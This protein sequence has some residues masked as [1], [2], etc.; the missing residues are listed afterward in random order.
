MRD[1]M[2]GRWVPVGTW[3][4]EISAVAAARSRSS[5][6]PFQ[7]TSFRIAATSALVLS[8][9]TSTR[10]SSACLIGLPKR[11]AGLPSRVALCCCASAETATTP[12]ARA[13]ASMAT[14]FV[15]MCLSSSGYVSRTGAPG[16]PTLPTSEGC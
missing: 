2:K 5:M 16:W 15:L 11:V 6:F 14:I 8:P 12:R 4:A 7:A 1:A 9:R 10:T 13:G 3:T